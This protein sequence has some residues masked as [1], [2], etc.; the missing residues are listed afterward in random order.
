MSYSIL[1]VIRR[2]W[3]FGIN[4][5][6]P[7]KCAGCGMIVGSL[8]EKCRDELEEL[9][10]CREI[11]VDEFHVFISSG[12]GNILKKVLHRFKYISDT[13]LAEA[14]SELLIKRLHL[15]RLNSDCD[16]II[17]VPIPLHARRER[18]RGFNQSEILAEL[19]VKILRGRVMNLLERKRETEPQARLSRNER[20][21]NV[22]GAFR[23]REKFSDKIPE[24]VFVLDDVITTGSTF[25]ECARVLKAAGVKQVYGIML[26]HGL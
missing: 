21:M 6:F 26:A 2:A 1:H 16:E 13:Y 5:L 23:I 10:S 9:F 14:L 12:H 11:V 22:K 7:Q 18:E 17:I 19:M 24:S 8:C 3:S 20:I 25:V 15:L 4:L